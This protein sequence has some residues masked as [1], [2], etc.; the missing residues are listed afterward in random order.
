MNGR[1]LEQHYRRLL[2]LYPQRDAITT[3]QVLADALCCSKRHMRAMLVKMQEA[4]WLEW[5]ASPGRG[6]KARLILLSN[7]HQL[8]LGKAEHLLDIGDLSGAAS[9]L[10]NE[11]NLVASLLRARLGYNVRDD[12]QSLRVPYYRTMLN[13]YPG[14]PL[15]RS[16]LH[17]VRQLFNGLTRISEESGNVEKDLAHYW[18]NIDPLH[19]R[20]Y[21]RPGVQFHDGRGLTSQD[22]VVSLMRSAR[23]PLF[24]HIRQVTEQGTLSVLIELTQPD[25]LLPQLLT[26]AAAMILPADHGSRVDF[27]SHPVGTGPYR[28]CDNDEWHL[29][30]CAF[31]NYFGFRGL[32]DEVE[33]IIW[34]DLAPDHHDLRKPDLPVPSAWLSSS[35]SDIDY[36]SGLAASLSGKPSDF[37]QEM[38]L[39]QGGY[40]LLC[41]ARSPRWQTIECRRWIREKLNPYL[42]VQHFIEPVRPFWVPAISLLPGWFHSLESGDV[43]HPFSHEAPGNLPAVLR[44]AYHRQHPEYPM[45]VEQMQKILG[46]E[47][48]HLEIVQLDYEQWAKGEGEADLWLGTVNFPVPEAWNVGAWLSGMPLLQ[49]SISGGNPD[50]FN[51]WQKQW[52]EGSLSANQLTQNV[53]GQ[54]WLQPLFHHWMRLKGPEQAQGIHLNNLGWFDFK[55]TWMEPGPGQ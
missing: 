3:L 38:F 27:S 16:E 20:F 45:L 32:L 25:E 15:R 55:S 46:G 30:M 5:H 36:A 7:E 28:V 33:V 47:G 23:L 18:H 13:L 17:L 10:G 1:R 37:S 49:H 40:F 54:G 29:R 24:S 8:L 2:A 39:E 44:L 41:D 43:V 42:L 51:A 6:H 26:D 21:L 31:D 4:G 34:P 11:K 9:L 48:V 12:Y 53:I 50:I 14:T 52:R 22:V 19:W 35:L